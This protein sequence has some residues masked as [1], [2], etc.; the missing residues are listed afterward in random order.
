MEQINIMV[1]LLILFDNGNRR[2][3]GASINE[4]NLFFSRSSGNNEIEHLTDIK[5]FVI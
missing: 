2:I 1:F 4:I 5:F 3:L